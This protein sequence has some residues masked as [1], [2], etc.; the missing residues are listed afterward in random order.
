MFRNRWSSVVAF[1]LLT[2]TTVWGAEPMGVSLL[3]GDQATRRVA[4]EL[5]LLHRQQPALAHADIRL[6]PGTGFSE[7]ERR[8]IATSRVIVIQ[9][10]GRQLLDAVRAELI[11]AQAGGARIYGYGGSDEQ[12]YAAL[13]IRRDERVRAYFEAGGA[14]NVR[15][16]LAAVLNQA[17]FELPLE[18][19]QS[20]PETGIYDASSGGWFADFDGFV[21]AYRNHVPGRPWIGFVVYRSNVAAGTTA[22]LDAVIRAL[23]RRGFNVLTVFGFPPEAP[24]ERFFFDGA[25]RSRVQAVVAA[26]AKIGV[27]P[28][29]L[30]PLLSR[31]DVPV[32]N[33]VSL[34]A[35]SADA[36][37]T[38]PVGMDTMERSWQLA[39]P[40]M[41]GLT[42][43]TVF[44]AKERVKASGDDVEFVEERPIAERVER[45]AD[46]VQRWVA[47][48]STAN[49]D[50]RVLLLYFN[51][52]PGR[53]GIGASYLNVLPDSLWQVLR[54]MAA[55]GYDVAGLPAEARALREDVTQFGANPAGW[56]QEAIDTLARSG[57]AVLVPVETYAGW[58]ASLPESARRKIVASWGE[59]T[60]SRHLTFMDERGRR[61][62]VLPVLQFGKVLLA[63]QPSRGKTDDPEK[64]YHD[65]QFPPPHQYLAFYFWLHEVARID[66]MVQFGTHGTHEWLPGKEAGLGADDAPEYLIRD[67][68]NL[69]AFIMDNAGEGTIAMRRGMATMITHL[70]PPF[71]KASL[72]PE[73][74]ALEAR[75]DDYKRAL[76][77]NPLL[78]DAHLDDIRR[79]TRST[80]IV[81]DL[82]LRAAPEEV[83]AE[84]LVDEIHHYLEEVSGRITPF[85]LHTLGVPPPPALLK[86]T[87]EAIAS[88]D[89]T[90]GEEARRARVAELEQL[91]RL[92]AEREIGA[93]I[94]GLDGRY[95]PAG[96][97]GDPLR[98]PDALPT[99]RNFYSFDPRRIPGASSYALGEKLARQL[100][101]DYRREHGDYPDKLAF[102][103]W[104]VE[105]M[106]N[107]GV[108]E[109]QIMYLM[110]VRPAY[111]T[112]GVV[113][114]V[115]VIPREELGRPRIDV[116]V[117]PSGLYRDLFSNVVALLD[118]AA[119]LAQAQDEP[120]NI[121]RRNMLALRTSLEKQ[122]VAP[123]L[124]ARLAAVRLFSVPPGAYGTN[125]ESA[126]DRSDSWENETDIAGMYLRR[127]GHLYGQG[128][129][130]D[131][132]TAD[133]SAEAGPQLLR[134]AL[135]GTRVT[136]H[137][138]SSH[139]YQVLDGDDPFAS[140][141]G[142][143]LAVRAI[144]GATPQV[145][146]S[147][148]ADP[149]QAKQETL[150]RFMGRELRSRY[151]NPQWIEAMQREGYAG[152]KFMNEVVQNLWGWQV[153]VPEVVDAAKWTELHAVY[154]EDR[155]GLGMEEFFRKA[156]NQQALYSMMTR[157]LEAVRKGYWKADAALVA[158]LGRRVQAL[159]ADLEV[160]CT[161]DRCPDPVLQKLVQAGLVPAPAPP[162]PQVSTSLPAVAPPLAAA[163]TPAPP[164]PQS[165]PGL[166]QV[167]GYE[168]E[169][170]AA[171]AEKR[172]AP[173]ASTRERIVWILL[174]SLMFAW[175]Y[176]RAY[177]QPWATGPRR[178]LA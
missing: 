45:L 41:A 135:S 103:L 60:E 39:M 37:R 8:H 139:V 28:E 79:L 148:L 116:T 64:L 63:P 172:V 118:Q 141:G 77:Q 54:R 163:P 142:L 51:F 110:G 7:T 114:G 38:S 31:L 130:G 48:R 17:G 25:G 107:E 129:W 67:V 161:P 176:W 108:Q 42:Q 100:L 6:L 86:S 89:T 32:I 12:E 145:M 119:G 128:F 175:G 43:P 144:D 98:T 105:T 104:G 167:R 36:W 154:V 121:A 127:M 95:I 96:P 125:I 19:P 55:E 87:A 177:P 50:K 109:A 151:L 150:A 149:V 65:I 122:G 178:S 140:F 2:T 69:Y 133:D 49:H 52:P 20:I 72:N 111:D 27:R 73:L 117:I 136:V 106:R 40:E 158:D 71:D 124:A 61:S 143:A 16:G 168:L 134:Q 70:T 131:S 76:Q 174:F 153:T 29:A 88:L 99:G 82:D 44:A 23:E 22:H 66:A 137:A 46:R 113:R 165:V 53:E 147:N 3:L 115:E 155:Y 156:G 91:L 101:D 93:V 9:L 33:A 59:P 81:A 57:R 84:E 5:A 92:S 90:L 11:E 35:T 159:G 75:I 97:G 26:G 160:R 123:A 85:G 56:D 83:A 10:V 62:F 112:R 78:A 47:L 157:M 126:V 80:G 58:F 15:N 170:V 173:T 146:I 13:G 24:I 94:A 171:K 102:T 34:Y 18:L 30:G 138:R 166:Q 132:G 68:P 164:A 169:Q 14:D 120:D 4:D 152:G 162:A 1:L 21:A 74:K